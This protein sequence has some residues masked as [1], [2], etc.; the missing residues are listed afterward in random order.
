MQG[1]ELLGYD[2][3]FKT[4]ARRMQYYIR[5]MYVHVRFKITTG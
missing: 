5:V 3:T 4:K 2:A 1:W